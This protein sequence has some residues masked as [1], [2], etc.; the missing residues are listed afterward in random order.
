MP[1]ILYLIIWS[2]FSYWIKQ[3]NQ[4]HLCKG[5]SDNLTD[6][7][8]RAGVKTGLADYVAEIAQQNLL[9][10]NGLVF[11]SGHKMSSTIVWNWY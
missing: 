1:L 9:T 2:Q 8:A 10:T 4:L 3:L 11:R 5:H 6:T 7:S